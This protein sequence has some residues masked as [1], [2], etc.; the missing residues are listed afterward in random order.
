MSA[1]VIK[2]K[3]ASRSSGKT[4][5]EKFTA[6]PIPLQIG[7]VVVA[8]LLIRWGV[9]KLKAGKQQFQYAQAYGQEMQGY[10]Q[11]GMNLSYAPTNYLVF[12]DEI[13]Q[14]MQYMGTYPDK[15]ADVLK[16]MNN[17]ADV[18]Q[19]IKAF[20]VRCIYF[21]GFCYEQTLPEALAEE[22]STSWIAEYNKILSSKG[23][24]Y[25]F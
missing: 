11:T 16:K 9:N 18:L 6:Q 24:R 4:F 3:G 5:F 10:Q 23:I 7:E 21:F 19:L 2:Y 17:D 25:R 14:A 13:E 1:A 8:A 12:A 22:V 20:G 15:I